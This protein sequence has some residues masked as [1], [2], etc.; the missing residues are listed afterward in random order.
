MSIHTLE[1]TAI[2]S[3]FAT[4]NAIPRASKKEEAIIEYML[5]FG[6]S[7]GLFAER[8]EVGNV[9]IRKPATSGY[10]SKSI[11][12][13]QAHLDMVHQKNAETD[14][15]FETSGIQMLIDG[16]WVRADG[17]TLGADNGIGVAAIMGVLASSDIPHPAIEALFTIDEET[18]MTGAKSLAPGWLTGS[19]LLNLDTE[20]DEEITIGCA[21]GVDVTAT[22]ALREEATTAYDTLVHIA[23]KGLQ[24][25][26]SGMD[27][28]K[29][30][31]NANKLLMRVLDSVISE[32][33]AR[34]YTVDGGGLR[35]AIPREATA[36]LAC[37]SADA[38]GIRDMVKRTQ[39]I[40]AKEYA[41]TEP[42]LAISTTQENADDE[43]SVLTVESQQKF[44]AVCNVAHHGV[45]R[46]SAVFP[47]LVETSNNVARIVLK[48]GKYT[49]L[50]LTRSA[51]QS[52]KEYLAMILRSTFEMLDAE[53]A[54]SGDYP[55]WEPEPEGEL[56]QLTADTY[57]RLFNS[58]PSVCAGHGG[59][60][61]GLI[62]KV[63]PN[64]KMVSVGPTI[65]GAHSPDERA[66]ISSVAKFWNFFLELLKNTP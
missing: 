57:R 44:V 24:G 7:L 35:N 10:E 59:L 61:C 5:S 62:G 23:V 47:D 9:L 48:S 12:V 18:G 43:L 64:L 3:H 28:H 53:V 39:Q 1:P 60:E 16:D 58:E 30:L 56:V 13:L 25:G 54:F 36:T 40:I 17:T 37:R 33:D 45:F 34:L 55:G 29:G 26:H 50:C 32:A 15:N 31:G 52:S 22:G 11:I 46:M 4:I 27:I 49:I 2:W 65:R 21:G 38:A 41:A 42:S 19:Y 8:D 66:S 6:K 63:Y 20:D 51:I 14:F